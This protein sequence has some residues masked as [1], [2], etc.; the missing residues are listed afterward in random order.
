MTLTQAGRA[1]L[2]LL[3]LGPKNPNPHVTMPMESTSQEQVACVFWVT[4]RQ[5]LSL[6]GAQPIGGVLHVWVN[7]LDYKMWANR[8]LSGTGAL[9]SVSS[10]VCFGF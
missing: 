9:L 1:S 3:L 4:V 7:V 5:S 10:N 2:N 8:L 6:K